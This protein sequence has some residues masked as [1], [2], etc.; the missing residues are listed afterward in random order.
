MVIRWANVGFAKRE[1]HRW[2]ACFSRSFGQEKIMKE[3]GRKKAQTRLNAHQKKVEEKGSNVSS[4]ER[5]KEWHGKAFR[6]VS[7][8]GKR[9]VV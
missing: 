4:M 3:G 2:L 5:L 1:S 7:S 8:G 6:W 9:V